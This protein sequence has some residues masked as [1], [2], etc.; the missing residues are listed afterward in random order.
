MRTALSVLAAAQLCGSTAAMAAGDLVIAFPASQEPASLDGHIDPY[1]S[2]WLFDSFVADPLVVLDA[3]GNYQPALATSWEVSEDGKTWTF[4]LREGVAFQDGTPFDAEAVKYNLERILDP[5]TASAQLA[6]DIGPFSKVEVVD[7][8]T[9]RISYDTPWVTLLD[10]LRRTPI[11][12]PTAAKAAG[13][14]DFDKQLVGAGPFTLEEWVPND[15]IVFKQWPDYGGWNAVQTKPGPVALDSVTVRFIGEEVVHGSVVQTGDADVGFAIPAQYVE[16]YKDS[17]E[18]T[19]YT[20]GQAGTGLQMVMNTRKPPLSDLRVRQ[21]LHYAVDQQAANDLLYDGLYAPS[22]GPLNNQHHC[23]WEGASEMYPYDVEKAKA[24]LEDAGWKDQDG[25]GIREAQGVE[26]VEDGTPLTIR[27]TILHHQ[28]I[29]EALQAQLRLAGI[30]LAVESVPGPVQLDRVRNRDF[31]LM[32]ERQRS[33][34]PLI[35]DQVWNSKWDQPGGWAWTGYKD[36]ELD[37]NLEQLRVLPDLE[38]RC[39]A[40]RAAQKIIM[41]NA[42]MLPTLSEPVFVAMS[43]RVKDFE[44]GAEG[45]WFFLHNT[46]LAE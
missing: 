1:Q 41:E 43:R 20:K 10:A 32:Y 13:L 23:F 33:P 8:L 30:D 46:S 21:A 14:A 45:N 37:S 25:D 12:S 36:P 7:P 27:Y 19:F 28:E 31:D 22:D 3:D 24:L 39:E 5:K 9:V 4:K 44:A 26:G 11:W 18:Y 29:G 34:D 16:D 2:T 38:A 6:S 42:L 17:D 15:H 35:L 40:A